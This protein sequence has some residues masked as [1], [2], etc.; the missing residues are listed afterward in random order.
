[1]DIIAKIMT[2]ESIVHGQIMSLEKLLDRQLSFQLTLNVKGI[3]SNIEF[4]ASQE[5]IQRVKQDLGYRVF[6]KLQDSW[7]SS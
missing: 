7:V 3:R 2:H 1:M 6:I 4:K 5:E